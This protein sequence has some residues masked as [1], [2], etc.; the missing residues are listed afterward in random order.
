MEKTP[1]QLQLP[2]FDFVKQKSEI[3][4]ECMAPYKIGGTRAGNCTCGCLPRL[5]T[6]FLAQWQMAA[7]VKTCLNSIQIW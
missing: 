2:R 7:V 4:S 1:L 6:N 3:R 5:R